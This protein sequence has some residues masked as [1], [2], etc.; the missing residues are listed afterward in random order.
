MPEGHGAGDPGRRR[1]D[2]AV[3]RDLLDAPGGGSEQERLPG[4]S[5]VDHLL[6]ELADPAAVR[7][8]DAEQA[9]V[10]DGPRVGH[11]ERARAGPRPDGAGEPVPH[12]ARPQVAELLRGVAA[13]E[14]VEHVLELAP[15][16]LGVGPRAPEEGVELVDRHAL[17]PGARGDGDDLLREHVERVAGHDRGLD[18]P[19]AHAPRHDGAL[20]QVR[21][22][23]G[24]DASARH[25]SHA[26]PGA[27]DALQPPRHRL[28]RLD[29]DDEVH[30]AHVDAELERRRRHQ[31]GQRPRLEQVLDDDALL[32]RQRAVV[33]AG[34]LARG[35]PRR[36]RLLRRQVVQ[37]Q[38][39]ALRRAAVVHEDEG[40]A[41][42]ADQAQQLR[43][44]RRPDAAPGRLAAGDRVELERRVRL[45][46]GL[47]R[48]VDAQVE[49][50]AHA[51]V[52][53]R[54]LPARPHQEPGDLVERLLRRREADA[55]HVAACL[56]GQPLQRHGEV[57]AA[58]GL[59]HRV[60]LVDDHPLRAGEELPRLRGEHQVQRLGRGDEHVGRAAQHRR[61]FPLRRVARAHA[62][63][64]SAPM[65][66]SG[67]FRLRSTSYP[68]A[69]S[70]EM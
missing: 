30:G 62:T 35:L 67:A 44:D 34:D 42:V 21:A 61:P 41:V 60:D 43:V 23:L 38:R 3:A 6:V 53:D 46:H 39:D 63:R 49:R 27:A 50:L 59:R 25:L 4:A 69:L 5:L 57:R 2:D 26:V 47:H 17:L 55:L 29:L 22:E 66:R 12:D 40:R 70:G 9:A 51:G 32:P 11:G 24:E 65:P 10:R 36:L 14:H 16:Q 20:E 68:R 37:P 52:D 31:A 64:T 45:D 33:G 15:L 1:D 7:Q 28:G 19:L 13:V 48:H 18:E 8:V 56:L 54:A 58:L